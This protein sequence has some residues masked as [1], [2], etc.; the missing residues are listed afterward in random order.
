[1]KPLAFEKVRHKQGRL[2][3]DNG[4]ARWWTW[5]IMFPNILTRNPQD[6]AAD[7]CERYRTVLRKKT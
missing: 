4:L 5:P 7:F 2:D 1:V 6:L 3:V